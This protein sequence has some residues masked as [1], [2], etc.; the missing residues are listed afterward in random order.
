M[1][2]LDEIYGLD[3]AVQKRRHQN[4]VSRLRSA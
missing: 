3:E 2:I 4:V 1:R